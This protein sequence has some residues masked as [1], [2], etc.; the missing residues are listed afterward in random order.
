[1]LVNSIFSDV[2]ILKVFVIRIIIILH[3]S[4]VE[5][6]QMNWLDVSYGIEKTKVCNMYLYVSRDLIWKRRVFKGDVK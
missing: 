2:C 4:N 6:I 1:M 3:V 5:V